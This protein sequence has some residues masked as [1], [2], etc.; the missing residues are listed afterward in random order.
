MLVESSLVCYILSKLLCTLQGV[1]RRRPEVGV[2]KAELKDRLMG[3]PAASANGARR[4]LPAVRPACV[5]YDPPSMTL[6]ELDKVAADVREYR[7][8]AVVICL[9]HLGK[10][11]CLG[12]KDVITWMAHSRARRM[13]GGASL[14]IVEQCVEQTPS[15]PPPPPPVVDPDVS[16]PPRELHAISSLD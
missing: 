7:V 9:D 8:S 4:A 16:E 1:W 11:N 14:T 15:A 5:R 12:C 10:A 6:S 13:C 2:T 3:K